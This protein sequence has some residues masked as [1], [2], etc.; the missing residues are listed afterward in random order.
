MWRCQ[1]T[2]IEENCAIKPLI[3][4][5]VLENLIVESSWSTFR[6][7]HVC[8]IGVVIMW[9][10]RDSVRGRRGEERGWSE[11][12]RRTEVN[13]MKCC[14]P[15]SA[16]WILWCAKVRK[17][18]DTG[19]HLTSTNSSCCDWLAPSHLWGAAHACRCIFLHGLYVFREAAIYRIRLPT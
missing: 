11:L 12:S 1:H 4:D 14:I 19:H 6:S 10:L 16:G 7:W 3:Y 18:S 5:V 15:D 13:G 8:V 17:Q 9:I 2:D